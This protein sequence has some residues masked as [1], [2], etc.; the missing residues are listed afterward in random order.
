MQVAGGWRA[1]WRAGPLHAT[2]EL[3]GR[4]EVAAL[5]N[6]AASLAVQ[7]CVPVAVGGLWSLAKKV[8]K[9]RRMFDVV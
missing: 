6:G 1:V 9:Q 2:S 3:R 5:H 8:K 4:A 7:A